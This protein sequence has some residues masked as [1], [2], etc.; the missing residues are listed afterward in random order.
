MYEILPK[1]VSNDSLEGQFPSLIPNKSDYVKADAD[2]INKVQ[3]I[4]IKLIGPLR[5]NL[6]FDK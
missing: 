3:Y 2:A 4:G 5:S 1:S 6:W